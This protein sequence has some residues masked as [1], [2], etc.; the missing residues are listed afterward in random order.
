MEPQQKLQI[1]AVLRS[2]LAFSEPNRD[3][4]FY[5]NLSDTPPHVIAKH[6]G[7]TYRIDVT[8]ATWYCLGDTIRVPAPGN[9]FPRELATLQAAVAFRR[10]APA[11]P[12][13]VFGVAALVIIQAILWSLPDAPVD[14]LWVNFIAQFTMWM[15]RVLQFGVCLCVP[16]MLIWVF[17]GSI[18]INLNPLDESPHLLSAG[19]PNIYP[20]V[21]LMSE[22]ADETPDTFLTRWNTSQAEQRPGQ[23]IVCITFRRPEGVILTG[24]DDVYKFVRDRPDYQGNDWP[25]EQCIVPPGTRFAAETWAEY[26]KYCNR[27]AE[28]YP[29]WVKVEKNKTADSLDALKYAMQAEAKTIEL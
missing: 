8:G 12:W 20:D 28:H 9:P 13:L 26:M 2:W 29:E 7:A 11:L 6:R 19:M 1:G 25:A 17:G 15:N 3:A 22:S 5:H 21:F 10:F 23:W 24:T 16:A 18:K 27:F 14:E 4:T